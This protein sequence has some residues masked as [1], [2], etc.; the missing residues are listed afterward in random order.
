M[1]GWRFTSIVPAAARASRQ[2]FE[3]C[4]YSAAA[5]KGTLCSQETWQV[6][7]DL[8]D[9]NVP[10]IV[11][12]GADDVTNSVRQAERFH[13]GIRCSK[14]IVLEQAGHFP[15]LEEPDR[16]FTA[17]RDALAAVRDQAPPPRSSGP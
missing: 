17:L 7:K 4:T 6:L 10:T 11:M 8:A 12:V 5:Y 9:V 1:R 3:Q 2:I 14:L 16:F 15:W 13:L